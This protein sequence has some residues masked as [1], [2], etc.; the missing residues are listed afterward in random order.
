MSVM[1]KK[2]DVQVKT[3][4]KAA[5][6]PKEVISKA[7]MGLSG[8]MIAAMKKEIV[9]CPLVKEEVPFLYCFTCPSYIRRVKGV[10]HCAAI[11]GP[12]G[13]IGAEATA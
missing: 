6:I 3:K 11:K 9:D 1:D 10:V 7:K 2:Y 5:R 8:K 4:D 13:S 12:Y